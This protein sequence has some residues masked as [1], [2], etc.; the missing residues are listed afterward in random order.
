[1]WCDGKGYHDRTEGD[2]LDSSSA[3][4][5]AEKKEKQTQGSERKRRAHQAALSGILAPDNFGQFCLSLESC[6]LAVSPVL[7]L[8]WVW[9]TPPVGSGWLLAFQ[10]HFLSSWLWFGLRSGQMRI[11]LSDHLLVMQL[12]VART[13]SPDAGS[14]LHFKVRQSCLIYLTVCS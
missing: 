7:W 6:H 2:Y 4:K 12:T 9:Q 13:V 8:G 3:C 11:P 5:S 14:A 10:H 1:M